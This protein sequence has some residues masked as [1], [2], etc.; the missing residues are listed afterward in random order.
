MNTSN[1]KYLVIIS[2]LIAILFPLFN[3]YYIL[4]SFKNIIIQ[5]AELD[6]ERIVGFFA[7]SI[8]SDGHIQSDIGEQRDHLEGLKEPFNVMKL[9]FFAPD[10]T[11]IYSSDT[12]EIGDVNVNDYF[13]HQV[14][15]GE[16]FTKVVE[17]ESGRT[18]EGLQ[19]TTDVVE[20]YVPIMQNGQF[21]GA[22]EIYYD[23]TAQEERVNKT[24]S[25]ASLATFVIIILFLLLTNAMTLRQTDRTFISDE[26]LSLIYRSPFAAPLIIGVLIFIAEGLVMLL[27]NAWP[28]IPMLTEAV[29]DST[30]LVMILAP[31]FYWFL[32]MPLMK[33]IQERQRTESELKQ[34]K[35]DADR[36]NQSKSLFLANMS[37]EIR[38][39]MN[40]VIGMTE[41]ALSGELSDQQRMVL[42]TV[43]SEA[44]NLNNLL[45]DILDL[46]KI[47]EGKLLIE[48]IPFDL[49]QL[50]ND[51][52]D[53]FRYR[54][55]EKQVTF[56]VKIHPLVPQCIVGDPTR[57]RQVLV[58]LCG[59]AIKFTPAGGSVE[60]AVDAILAEN[61]DKLDVLHFAVTDTGIGISQE[62]QALIFDK[63]T[64]ADGTTTR[65]Y[66]GTGLGTSISK[67]LVEMMGGAIGMCS[68]L[69]RGS[70]FWFVL[71]L[72][73]VS[74]PAGAISSDGVGSSI[75][76]SVIGV[77]VLV[78]EDYPTNQKVA[79]A[80]L[81]SAGHQVDIVADGAEAIAAF[82][83]GHYDLILMDVQMPNVD[84][85]EASRAIRQRSREDSVET[86]IIAM[87]AHAMLGDREKCLAAGMNDYITKPLNKVELLHLVTKWAQDCRLSVPADIDVNIPKL[88]TEDSGKHPIDFEKAVAEFDGMREL[89]VNLL[90][91][92]MQLAAEQVENMRNAIDQKDMETLSREAHTIKG[93]AA[94]VYAIPVS[95]AAKKIEESVENQVISVLLQDVDSLEGE[96]LRLR[97]YLAQQVS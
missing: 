70:E 57:I 46:S 97:E 89:V 16:K 17:K 34:A 35:E 30:L 14:A 4:P 13:H 29:L 87:T 94:N 67:E 78:A 96:L 51:F 69:G 21:I 45:N 44:D 24:V 22:A 95:C 25:R 93:G 15:K 90:E 31:V 75:G 7:Q 80:Y 23:I 83:E 3:I 68:E 39:P 1:I 73:K 88:E 38:T 61:P 2:S 5:N 85:Y 63:F 74:A 58:N 42:K 53:P 55:S 41:I 10:G 50:L 77:R 56:R 32:V 71:P 43:R 66:G 79:K 54:A 9:K 28:D 65:K 18:L 19:I 47:E 8:I 40:G 64:Q 91:E 82:V 27:L 86:P 20:T 81:E 72:V 76:E 60:I 84:G 59:N 52:A 92:F 37:H 26:R 36:A 6:A 48:A 33:H 49:K 11:I 12:D 62:Q